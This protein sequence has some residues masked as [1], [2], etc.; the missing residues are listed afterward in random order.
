MVSIGRMNSV[1]LCPHGE[2]KVCLLYTFFKMR[3]VQFVLT[4]ISIPSNL[5]LLGPYIMLIYQIKTS[6]II[7]QLYGHIESIV[8][9]YAL[10]HVLERVNYEK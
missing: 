8:I 1:N 3:C 6:S 7:G 10:C 5:Y 2:I 9:K 4:I